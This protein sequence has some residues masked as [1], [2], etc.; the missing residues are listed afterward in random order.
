[1]KTKFVVVAILV[2]ILLSLGSMNSAWAGSAAQTVP[3]EAPDN[4]QEGE[5]EPTATSEPAT[6]TA[7]SPPS[8][9]TSTAAPLPLGGE[10]PP[11]AFLGLFGGMPVWLWFCCGLL[12]LF[13]LLPFVIWVLRNRRAEEPEAAPEVGA[14]S[15]MAGVEE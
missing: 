13:L 4:V 15:Q 14:A 5:E 12:F 11:G 2:V 8:T 7:T 10:T 3:S 6:A 1:M 9:P